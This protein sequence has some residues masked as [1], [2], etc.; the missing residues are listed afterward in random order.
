MPATAHATRA[1]H[2]VANADRAHW[3]DQALW[4]VRV[5]RDRQAQSLP[6]WEELREAAKAGA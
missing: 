2:F 5:K 6:E 1:R 4:W 3:H